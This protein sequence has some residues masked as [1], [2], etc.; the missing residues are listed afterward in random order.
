MIHSPPGCSHVS[1]VATIGRLPCFDNKKHS[2]F[3]VERVKL[4]YS[5]WI[6]KWIA[7]TQQTVIIQ[8]KNKIFTWMP[9]LPS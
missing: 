9:K 5:L 7:A 8:N 6:S 3:D 2:S 1:N 4:S